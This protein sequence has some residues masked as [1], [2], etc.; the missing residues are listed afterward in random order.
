MR[1]IAHRGLWRPDGPPENSL[2][3]FEAA[4]AAGYD[5]ELDVR[6]SSDGR[7][8]VFHDAD[9]QRMTGQSGPVAART[10]A[11]L[12]GVRLKDSDER[13]PTL[14]E[15]LTLIAGRTTVYVEVKTAV[16][17]EGPLECAVVGALE[18]SPEVKAAVIGF[19]PFALAEVRRLA[20]S[21]PLGLSGSGHVDFSAR[22]VKLD[23]DRPFQ[24]E[25]MALVRP[26]M[27][28][29]GKDILYE[30][31]VARLRSRGLPVVAWTIRSA[32]EASRLQPYCDA[33]LFEGFA[34]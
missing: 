10:A 28:I 1:P 8:V 34:A 2:A 7:A 15:A 6:L 16:G 23:R 4:C 19:N 21:V 9:L 20:P 33:Y 25:H 5:I 24:D 30:D 12:A 13:L 27:L 17:D 32:D 18:R 31:R 26:N 11:S 3:A 22:A 29:V 14:V